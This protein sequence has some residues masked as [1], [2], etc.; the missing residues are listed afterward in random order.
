MGMKN[1]KNKNLAKDTTRKTNHKKCKP[2]SNPRLKTQKRKAKTWYML[3]DDSN[4]ILF[5]W[6]MKTKVK[7]VNVPQTN[8][9]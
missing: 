2:K 6:H 5:L 4:N 8:V 1:Y 3:E 7:Q 9:E